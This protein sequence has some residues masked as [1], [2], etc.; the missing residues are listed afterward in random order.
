[1]KIT[2][3]YFIDKANKI[4]RDL[5]GLIH[6]HSLNLTTTLGRFYFLDNYYS[7]S[8]NN[9]KQTDYFRQFDQSTA[10][11]VFTYGKMNFMY[12]IL[13]HFTFYVV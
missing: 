12:R 11:T 1:M 8:K 2:I 10:L 6:L 9:Y 7:G 13:T 4:S 5:I 3:Y